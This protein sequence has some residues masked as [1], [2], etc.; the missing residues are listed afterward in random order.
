M[1]NISLKEY[2]V[3]L[4]KSQCNENWK[5]L[6]KKKS[7]LKIMWKLKYLLQSDHQA[8]EEIRKYFKMDYNEDTTY[9]NS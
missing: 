2:K 4:C 3:Y 8:R 1:L 7:G 6:E 5:Q 9:P